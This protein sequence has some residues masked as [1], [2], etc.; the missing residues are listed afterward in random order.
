MSWGNI[1]GKGPDSDTIHGHDFD[2]AVGDNK[3]QCSKCGWRWNGRRRWFG[4]RG[5]IEYCN[6]N[7]V[8][9]RVIIDEPL[10]C[11]WWPRQT[12]FPWRGDGGEQ[13]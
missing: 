5:F 4:F 2:W 8:Q 10:L 13:S 3:M 7:H 9:I 11:S 1:C 12:I 6:F